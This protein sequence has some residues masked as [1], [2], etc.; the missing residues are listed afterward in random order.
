MRK[1]QITALLLALAAACAANGAPT[2][3]ENP[4]W[5][6]FPYGVYIGGNNPDGTIRDIKDVEAVRQAIERACRDVAAHH[7]NAVWPN[8]LLEQHL[9]AWLEMGRK[10]GIRVVPQSG[11]PPT[12]I[13]AR[14][15]EDKQDL[16]KRVGSA[17]ERLTTRHGGDSALLA[18][19]LGEESKPLSWVYEGA[20]EVTR[21]MEEWDPTHP[22][23]MLDNSIASAKLNARVVR[24]QAMAMDCY[25]FFCNPESGPVTP[26]AIKSYWTR[27]C[28]GMRVAADSV[29]AP[30]WMMGQGMSLTLM[31]GEQPPLP[32]WRRPTPAEIR[33]QFWTAV[34]QG[35]KGFFYFIYHGPERL[36][37]STGESAV[38]L[39]DHDLK[40]T[41]QYRVAAELGQQ[42]ETLAPLLLKLDVAPAE[43]QLTY[44]G[45]PAVSVQTHIHRQTGARFLTAVNN[46]WHNAQQIGADPPSRL[47]PLEEGEGLFDLRTGEAHDEASSLP[48]GAGT[49][50]FV[51]TAADWGAFQSA[52]R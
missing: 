51:G 5:D 27:Q 38:G 2:A 48:P 13:S 31:R 46:D 22:A 47:A 4:L 20:T 6:F 42:L 25:P 3:D 39:L 44:G 12:F 41:P 9:P 21:M 15:Y 8:N 45:N 24:P 11:G 26:A 50:Y 49:V 34:Q 19:S 36:P 43:Q 14:F 10:Y 16:V 28:A 7:M 40:E 17:Y 52:S 29:D 1:D 30:F 32:I 18:W 33:W 23:I 37:G 35:A